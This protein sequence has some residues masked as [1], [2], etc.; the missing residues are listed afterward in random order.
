[1]SAKR[2]RVTF[3][4]TGFGKFCGVANNPTTEIVAE[5]R[6]KEAEIEVREMR[7]RE[8]VPQ[9]LQHYLINYMWCRMVILCSAS[10]H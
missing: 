8:W 7:D 2:S 9:S 4:V 6:E 3:H 1:M 5:L 10:Q